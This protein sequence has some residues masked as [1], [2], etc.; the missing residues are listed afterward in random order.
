MTDTAKLTALA[1]AAKAALPEAVHRREDR[2]WRTDTDAV[3]RAR[4]V[5]TPQKFLRDDPAWR[6]KILIDICG[7]DYPDRRRT[8]RGGLSPAQRAQ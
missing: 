7:A 1:E 5:E 6:F 8:F 2:V 3:R 4:I